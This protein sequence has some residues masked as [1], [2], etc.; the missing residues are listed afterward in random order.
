MA[1]PPQTQNGPIAAGQ[2]GEAIGM[3]LANP[4]QNIPLFDQVFGPYGYDGAEIVGQLET[5]PPPP[6][7]APSVA[8]PN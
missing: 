8:G 6:P 5:A 1:Q 7:E 2:W 4:K 3:L